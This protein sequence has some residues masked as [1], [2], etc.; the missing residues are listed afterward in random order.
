MGADLSNSNSETVDAT[1]P[2]DTAFVETRSVSEDPMI[3]FQADCAIEE[4]LPCLLEQAGLFGTT[5]LVDTTGVADVDEEFSSVE[6]V[7]VAFN[8]V[9]NRESHTS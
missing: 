1:I 2:T 6:T 4:N 5:V 3:S 9:S 8:L 7:T